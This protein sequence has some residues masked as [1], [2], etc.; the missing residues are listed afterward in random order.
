[1]ANK[2]GNAVYLNKRECSVQRRSQKVVEEAPSVFIDPET[3]RKMDE[4]ACQLAKAVN[5]CSAGT[6]EFF[7]RFTKEFLFPRNEYPSSRLVR[8]N[9]RRFWK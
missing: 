9:M 6:V 1:M 5:Y 3:R 8:E 2:H 7:G 4:Q